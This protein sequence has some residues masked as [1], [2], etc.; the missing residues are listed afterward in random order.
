M[1]SL[2]KEGYRLGNYEKFLKCNSAYLYP[3]FLLNYIG[4]PNETW[5]TDDAT[6]YI[7]YFGQKQLLNGHTQYKF[8]SFK[9]TS[10]ENFVTKIEQGLIER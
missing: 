10:P 3:D 1:D 8:L 5:S 7:F 2:G 9:V 6:S 4:K